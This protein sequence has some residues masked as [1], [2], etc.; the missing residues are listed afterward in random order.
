MSGDRVS[1]GGRSF[2]IDRDR[3]GVPHVRAGAADDAWC[4][5]G[6]AAAED[7]L[8]QLEFDRRRAAGTWAA[9][10]GRSGLAADRLARRL[11]L[12]DAARDDLAAMDPTTASSFAA[13]AEGVNA[14]VERHGLPE[15]HT[16]AGV[17]WTPWRPEH[18]VAA[19]KV[20]HVVM[21]VWQYKVARA[22]LLARSGLAAF[23]AVDPRPRPGMRVT[24]PADGRLPD[25]GAREALLETARADVE[26]AAGHLGFLSE[27]EAG[28]NA[29]V[30]GPGRSATGAPIL[31]NDSHRALDVPN[32]YWQAHV[33]CDDFT[34]SGATFPGLPGFPHFGHNG[35]VGWA[36][37][38]AAADAQDLY[39]E[40]FRAADGDG[41]ELRTAGGWVP[42][43]PR[44]EVIEVRDGDPV[45]ESCWRTSHGPVVHGDPRTG[46]ALS[47]R[48]T[49]TDEPCRQFGVLGDMLRAD[50]VEP[51]LESQRSWVD[52]VNNL[53]VADVD[54]HIGYQL[55]GA[56]PLRGSTAAT[57]LPVPGWD[58]AHAWTGRVAPEAM[59][60]T[61]DPPG[62]LIV[63]ANNTVSADAEPVVSHAL[64]DAYRAERIHEL[65]DGGG[66]RPADLVAWQGDT[67]SVAARRWA[68]LLAD[69]GPW[70]GDAE[71]ARAAVAA[72]R[73]DLRADGASAVLHA[74]FRRELL[75]ALLAD[76]L[77]PDAARALLASPL[78]G[79][80]VLLR[81]WFA[82]LTWPERPGARL[83]AQDLDD[84]LLGRCLAA[85]WAA[86]HEDGDPV[87]SEVHR[88]AARHP[89]HP[90]VGTRFDPPSAGIGG[91]NE[92]VQA[93]AYE[94]LVGSPFAI[95]NLSVYRQVLDLADLTA[96]GWVVPGGVSGRPGHPHAHDQLGPWSR[97]ELLPMH[98]DT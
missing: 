33:S 2:A 93:A 96:S 21:G 43:E 24:V 29:W 97:H 10:V 98:P 51:L 3:V 63:S 6:Y 5:L 35:R 95:T 57:Q 25:D 26:A 13:Y 56:L 11:R 40:E 42:V 17:D 80:P 89:L 69:R 15:E 27:V 7:R 70:S 87:W 45:V 50:G 1:V 48:W 46:H 12:G 34:V 83:P 92:T 88:T 90:V 58:P 4:G 38:N 30:V 8:W 52:P 18:S 37:T 9:V 36:I 85:A 44:E 32:V 61:V 62:Q 28:S 73:G 31:A 39:V 49:A 82:E 77:G 20:R 68:D 23:D 55:R 94:W 78:P 60:R 79:V 72:G 67:V 76:R 41:L 74:C 71:R 22:T 65:A 19:F 16:A 59:P 64:N 54:G 84:E 86:A 53:L 66:H 75:A 47:L 81:R 14:F 91:D